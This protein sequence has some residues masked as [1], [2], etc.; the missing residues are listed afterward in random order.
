MDVKSWTIK[1]AECRRIGAFE[2]WCCRRLWIQSPL[3]CKEIKPVNSKGNQSWIFIRRTDTEAPILSPPDAKSRSLEKTLMLG[4]TEGRRRGGWQR[5]RWLDGI[6]DSVD[7]SLSKLQEMVV[8]EAWRAAV[9]GVA[10]NPT[11]LSNWTM[12]NTLLFM[13][14]FLFFLTSIVFR[15]FWVSSE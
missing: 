6:T 5:T 4:K 10:K 15:I 1:K 14:V 12:S 7:I 11:Q 3:D 13:S 9:H 2:L 8:R